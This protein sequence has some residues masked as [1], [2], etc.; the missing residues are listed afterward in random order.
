MHRQHLG[1]TA[2]AG[3]PQLPITSFLPFLGTERYGDKGENENVQ[4]EAVTSSMPNVT[5]AGSS[6]LIYEVYL[7]LCLERVFLET[8][9]IAEYNG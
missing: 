9:C 3:K 6:M 5:I 4:E 7:T 1:R 8:L 2:P